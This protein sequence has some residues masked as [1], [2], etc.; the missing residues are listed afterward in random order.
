M[1][2]KLGEAEK[3]IKRLENDLP[4]IATTGRIII[5]TNYVIWALK[6]EPEKVKAVIVA[7]NI[8]NQYFEKV[9]KVA[10]SAKVPLIKVN[11]NSKELGELCKRPHSILTLGIYD[12]GLSNLES[13]IKGSEIV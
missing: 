8:P 3:L 1:N 4:L 5:G 2:Q 11:K 10:L 13:A 7:K 12:F 6:N 9:A